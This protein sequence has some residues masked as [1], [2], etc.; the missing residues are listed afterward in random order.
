MV[1]GGKVGMEVPV[2]ALA[3]QDD[4]LGFRWEA[5][6]PLCLLFRLALGGD[7]GTE[8]FGCMQPGRHVGKDAC[9][10]QVVL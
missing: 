9:E 10:T 4:A 8:S 6:P 5:V 3:P 1:G 7:D 2:V